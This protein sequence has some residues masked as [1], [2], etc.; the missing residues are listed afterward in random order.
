MKSVP[1]L[2]IMQ[3]GGILYMHPVTYDRFLV[4]MKALI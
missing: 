2:K 3:I 4:E 1:S